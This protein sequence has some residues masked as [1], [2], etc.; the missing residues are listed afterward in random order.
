MY[1]VRKDTLRTQLLLKPSKPWPAIGGIT[2]TEG[3]SPVLVPPG[4]PLLSI[5]P[6]PSSPPSQRL[7]APHA[8]PTTRARQ[9]PAHITDLLLLISQQRKCLCGKSGPCLPAVGPTP[10]C[11]LR[12]GLVLCSL[13]FLL[14][15]VCLFISCS[16]II[17]THSIISPLKQTNTA[18]PNAPFLM[19][20][21]LK[22]SLESY[23]VPQCLI[24]LPLLSSP[25]G[26]ALLARP[27]DLRPP[28]SPRPSFLQI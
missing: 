5:E 6:L 4:F 24:S 21:A 19:D 20:S 27:S 11:P 17:F 3:W 26:A 2:E 25:S 23:L 7:Q 28:C 14:S 22:I 9:E 8:Q 10:F 13:S 18:M 1:R 12:L 16:G 15:L